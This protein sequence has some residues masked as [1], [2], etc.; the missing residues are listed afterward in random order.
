MC[1]QSRTEAIKS[2]SNKNCVIWKLEYVSNSFVNDT[3]VKKNQKYITY[4][5]LRYRK[6]FIGYK[7]RY[8]ILFCKNGA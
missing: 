7:S 5:D 8:W 1:P 4:V 3:S 2:V 6:E